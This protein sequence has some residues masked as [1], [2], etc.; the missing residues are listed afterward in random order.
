[1]PRIKVDRLVLH[2]ALRKIFSGIFKSDI[3]ALINI[4]VMIDHLDNMVI[5]FHIKSNLQSADFATN[6]DEAQIG[7]IL[8]KQN[9]RFEIA[10]NKEVSA[11]LTIPSY[12]LVESAK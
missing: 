7:K 6:V 11:L 9:C 1:M 8:D 2:D 5:I 4:T 10:S 3:E 12:R